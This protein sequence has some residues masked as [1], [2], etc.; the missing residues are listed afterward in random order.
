MLVGDAVLLLMQRLGLHL[1]VVQG[2]VIRGQPGVV[3]HLQL[4]LL[5]RQVGLV[6]RLLG[7]QCVR[8]HPSKLML[9]Q[10]GNAGLCSLQSGGDES[11]PFLVYAKYQDPNT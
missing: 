10:R 7:L 9:L 8:V 5:R 3:V 1:S 6:G 2:S 11:Q 4:L